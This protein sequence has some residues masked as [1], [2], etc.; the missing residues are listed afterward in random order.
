MREDREG[1]L[2]TTSLLP[3]QDG[4]FESIDP[5][6]PFL[7]FELSAGTFIAGINCLCY[8][9]IDFRTEEGCSADADSITLVGA[10]VGSGLVKLLLF[11]GK[12]HDLLQIL[13]AD[14]G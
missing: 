12:Q 6:K 7:G 13:V 11:D 4:A 10:V 9:D 3:L 1:P 8:V 2:L 14:L 5:I